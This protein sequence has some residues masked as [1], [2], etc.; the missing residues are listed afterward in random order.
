M[1]TDQI[2]KVKCAVLEHRHKGFTLVEL[3]VVIAII[4]LLLSIL[5]PAL[6]KARIQ[7]YRVVCRSQMHQIG[8]AI[9]A[10][11]QDNKNKFPNG[12][13]YNYPVSNNRSTGFVGTD[14]QPYLG[15][16]DNTIF[17]CPANQ[18]VAKM[19]AF[20]SEK[21]PKNISTYQWYKKGEFNYENQ[22]NGY[23]IYFFYF[24]NYPT[25]TETTFLTYSEK[26]QKAKGLIYPSTS[27]GPRAKLFQDLAAY[28]TPY[29]EFKD[30]H[31]Y[32]NALFTDGSVESQDKNKLKMQRRDAVKTIHLW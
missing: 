29:P 25:T 16:K 11:A 10:F 20:H 12:C 27:T 13:F 22:N 4:A 2:C 28:S 23:W 5:M 32:P 31:P 6:N 19:P 3:L 15:A 18:T 17:I 1:T 14:I 8:I 7:S 9:V 30:N 24:G 21:Q 26:Q